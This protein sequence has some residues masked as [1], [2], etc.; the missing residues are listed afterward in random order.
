MW[1]KILIFLRLEGENF[2]RE[3]SENE[4]RSV[5]GGKIDWDDSAASGIISVIVSAGW[6]S[7]VAKFG[8]TA[9]VGAVSAVGVSGMLV[10]GAAQ[11]YQERGGQSECVTQV[12]T[13]SY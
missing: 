1:I 3:L 10:Y 4:L 13:Y 8:L 11:D 9:C 12:Q 2:M 5:E 7:A 6:E